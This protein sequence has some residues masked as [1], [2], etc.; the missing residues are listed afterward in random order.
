[1]ID[2]QA[3]FGNGPASVAVPEAVPAVA[4]RSTAHR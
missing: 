2:L 1:M 4:E 3:I